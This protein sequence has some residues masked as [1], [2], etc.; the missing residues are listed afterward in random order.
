MLEFT[1]SHYES[2]AAV[3]RLARE[4]IYNGSYPFV[5]KE[6]NENRELMVNGVDH[7]VFLFCHLF[8]DDNKNFSKEKFE[9]VIYNGDNHAIAET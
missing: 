6:S 2:V 8:E 9:Q 1:R 7:A 3:L 5:E 4:N